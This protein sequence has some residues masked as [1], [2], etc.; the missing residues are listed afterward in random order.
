MSPT[1]DPPKLDVERRTD[2]RRVEDGLTIMSSP[3]TCPSATWSRKPYFITEPR[4]PV[5][6]HPQHRWRPNPL[7]ASAI[8]PENHTFVPP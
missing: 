4:P 1:E 6:E 7:P 3:S 2:H 8:L 5:R